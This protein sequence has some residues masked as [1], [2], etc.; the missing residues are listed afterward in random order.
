MPL[1]DASQS[2]A[3]INRTTNLVKPSSF[4][5]PPSSSPL[6]MPPLASAMPTAPPPPVHQPVSLQRPYGSPMLQPFPP[7]TPPP[8]L[9]PTSIPAPNYGPVISRDK[10]REALLMLVQVLSPPL[11]PPS[12]SLLPPTPLRKRKKIYWSSWHWILSFIH[13]GHTPVLF[14]LF[15]PF[16]YF[17]L[18]R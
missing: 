15:K 18:I 16:S 3:T 11:L 8:S 5:G 1:L 9:T 7:P 13:V 10:V 14:S 2:S 6:M 12:P 4:F 17:S